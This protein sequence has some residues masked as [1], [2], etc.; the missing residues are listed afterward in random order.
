[1]AYRGVC[2]FPQQELESVRKQR[3]DA[4]PAQEYGVKGMRWEPANIP[5]QAVKRA[6]LLLAELIL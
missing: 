3:E 5:R 2:V 6:M 1:M 4:D